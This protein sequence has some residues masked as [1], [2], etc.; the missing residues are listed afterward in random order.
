MAIL[1]SRLRSREQEDWGDE[2]QGFRE[3][4]EDP[5]AFA[6]GV[7]GQSLW[8]RQEE[9][10]GDLTRHRRVA[11]KACHASGK[12]RLAAVATLWWL[13]RYPDGIVVTTAPTWPQ[14]TKLLWGEIRTAVASLN[15]PID[16]PAPNTTEL[17]LGPGNYAM[18][19]STN[20]GV[21]FQG[22]HGRLLFAVDEGPG[23]RPDIYEAIEGARAGGD[24]A[25]LVVGNP[26]ARGGPFVDAFTGRG[27]RNWARHTISA[28]DTPNLVTLGATQD[29]RLAR[30]LEMPDAELDLESR[31]YLTRRRWVREKFHEWGPGH[32][33]WEAKVLGKFPGQ[34]DDALFALSD[35]HAAQFRDV[36][37]PDGAPWRAGLD[38]AGPGEDETALCIRHG[39]QIALLESWTKA[40]PRQEVLD[41]LLPYREKGVDVVCDADGIGYYMARHLQDHGL[42]IT[43]VHVGTPAG[44]PGRFSN[45]KAELYWNLRLHLEQGRIGGLTDE[46]AIGQ[47]ATVLYDHNTKGQIVIESKDKLRTRGQKSPD[48]AEAVILAF[49]ESAILPLGPVNLD[50]ELS[51]I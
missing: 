46:L 41:A 24:V 5:V 12:T 10:L 16:L 3:M 21:R 50:R 9:I 40:D 39:D 18:G 2:R 33:L 14:V 13:L 35:L 8:W 6:R 32:P 23:V 48:R 4:L 28:F 19:L 7:L 29:E 17:T 27:A 51:F 44:E 47:L 42:R 22:F 20:E 30:L 34:A 45:L 43:D 15:L 26:M 25:V 11:V 37:I 31:P 36:G 1:P 38:V 49:A